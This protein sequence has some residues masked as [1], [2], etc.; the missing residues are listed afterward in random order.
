MNS[1]NEKLF[2]LTGTEH[3]IASAYHPQTNGLDERLNQTVTKSLVKYNNADHFD[4]D[5]N[6]ESVLFSYRTSV[7]ATIKYT[8]FFLM[9]GREAIQLQTGNVDNDHTLVT[10]TDIESEAQKYATQLD[11]TRTEPFMKIASNIQNA[12][13]KHKLYYDCKHSRA[14]FQLGNQVLLRNMRK[15]SQKGGKMDKEWTGTFMCGKGLY[16]LKNAHGKVLK[17]KSNSIQLKI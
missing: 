16:S 17:K 7:H 14:E 13:T 4:W 8:P 3:R 10:I 1:L 2:L 11:M 9:Y 12:H 6:L 5:E 15:L